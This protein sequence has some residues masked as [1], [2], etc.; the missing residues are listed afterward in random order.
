[1]EL[2]GFGAVIRGVL[3]DRRCFGAGGMD[4]WRAPAFSPCRG[5]A[6]DQISVDKAL[7]FFQKKKFHYFLSKSLEAIIMTLSPG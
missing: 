4:P 2:C 1:M 5:A 6:S 3:E 7:P